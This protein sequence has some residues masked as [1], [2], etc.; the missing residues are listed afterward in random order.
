MRATN[1]NGRWGAPAVEGN[2]EQREAR[3]DC[4]ESDAERKRIDTAV[5]S[6]A[7]L[8][9]EVH[10][11]GADAFLLAHHAGTV[12]G[13]VHGARLLEV[14]LAGLVAMGGAA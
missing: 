14:A 7:R 4:A 10:R 13:V 2:K 12:I 11:I 5:A 3:P 8:G 9:V 6:F 1:D